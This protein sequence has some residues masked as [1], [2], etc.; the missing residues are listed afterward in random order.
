MLTLF[1]IDSPFP[2][3]QAFILTECGTSVVLI[4]QIITSELR[5]L[6]ARRSSNKTKLLRNEEQQQRDVLLFKNAS[7][8][9]EGK[10][11]KIV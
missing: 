5:L 3:S 10:Q 6:D 9:A 1:L 7:S 11:Q 4:K 2:G 8:V